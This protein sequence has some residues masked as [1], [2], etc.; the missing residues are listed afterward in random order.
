MSPAENVY[1]PCP[2]GSGQ[3]YKFCCLQSDRDRR[4]ELLRETPHVTGLDG[5]PI[6]VLDLEEGERA[7]QRGLELVEQMKARE[8]IPFL[9]RAIEAAPIVPQPYNN[10]AMARFLVG[11]P[12]RALEICDHVDRILD[13]GNVFALGNRIHFLLVLG[14][15]RDAEEA[16]QRILS[17]PGR[18]GFAVYKKCE[19]LARL[20]WH[21]HVYG[22]ATHGLSRAGECTDGLKFFAGTAAAN[23]AR[24]DVA[25]RYL[26]EARGDRVHGRMARRHLEFLRRRRG[27]A[28][29]FE[30][31]PY[32]EWGH[33]T[34]PGLL[35]RMKNGDEARK[36]P[37]MIEAMVCLL[38][39]GEKG[40]AAIRMLGLIGTPEAFDALRRIAFGTFGSDELRLLALSELQDRAQAGANPP[41]DVWIKGR[42]QAIRPGRLEVTTEIPPA[43]PEGLRDSLGHLVEALHAQEWKHAEALGR[44]IVAKAPGCAQALHNLAMAL[45]GQ[46][47]EADG[48]DML[49]RAIAADPAYLFAPAWLARL[50]LKQERTVEARAILKGVR[51]PDRAHPDGYVAYLL[52]QAEVALL[53]GDV[54][55]AADAWKAAEK[56]APQHPAVREVGR[57]GVRRLAERLARSRERRREVLM[58]QRARLLPRDAG[59]EDC[60]AGHTLDQLREI[61]TTL[62][63]DAA[64]ASKKDDL[65]ER[66]LAALGD[67]EVIRRTIRALPEGAREGLRHVWTKG[68]ACAH[69]DFTRVYG[70][71]DSAEEGA[72]SP[73]ARLRASG[74]LAEGTFGG[75]PS[76][77]IPAEVRA[78]VEQVFSSPAS[79][80]ASSGASA[81]EGNRSPGGEPS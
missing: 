24:Y 77:L 36:F 53:E 31:W 2:C 10:L 22:T 61:A 69:D 55:A 9:E 33:W 4:H 35:E 45:L 74:L 63:L 37:G 59:L 28:T 52:A 5:E 67:P 44:E 73:F 66:L 79:P 39:E 16:G 56:V 3:K 17:L 32:L 78:V 11:E 29:L 70:R 34:S 64:A 40:D 12:E 57:D 38:N 46:G 7:H 8:A 25:E 81:S 48:E 41:L 23:L 60:L 58:R 50:L 30:D 20:R 49:R 18:D 62:G 51:L 6:V 72:P 75:R 14:R 21:D 65:L 26:R 19:A 1:R 76:V 71:E 54:E 47:R 15:R 43:F 42:W 13:P 27:P 68:W 80:V